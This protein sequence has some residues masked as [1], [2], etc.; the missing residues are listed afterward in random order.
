M[1]TICCLIDDIIDF[2]NKQE[3]LRK[4][5]KL[6][7]R[8]IKHQQFDYIDLIGEYG[9][10]YWRTM[11]SWIGG[12]QLHQYKNGDILP[13]QSMNPNT[14]SCLMN[15]SNSENLGNRQL[16]WMQENKSIWT[17]WKKISTVTV[18]ISNAAWSE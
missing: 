10:D 18:I 13:L 2:D 4:M 1:T 16:L 12:Y 15:L 5:I 8:S 14:M 7:L 11:I 6:Y 17:K 9:D 3:S